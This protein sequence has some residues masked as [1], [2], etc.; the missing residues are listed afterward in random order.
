VIIVWL[1]VC[2]TSATKNTEGFIIRFLMEQTFKRG[3]IV[4]YFAWCPIDQINGGKES[5]IPKFQWHRSMGKK[6]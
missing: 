2:P 6:S 4:D 1:E 5:I 3:F